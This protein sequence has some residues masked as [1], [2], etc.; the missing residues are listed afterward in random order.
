M[1]SMG[2]DDVSLILPDVQ[3]D[4]AS[5]SESARIELVF[6]SILAHGGHLASVSSIPQFSQL[7]ARHYPSF[8]A[9]AHVVRGRVTTP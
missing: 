7:L 9:Y 1:N 2:L 4:W 6:D 8:E 5:L 3:D